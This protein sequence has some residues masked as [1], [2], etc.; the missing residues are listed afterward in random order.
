MIDTGMLQSGAGVKWFLS[1]WVSL[2]CRGYAGDVS[3]IKEYKPIDCTTNPSLLFKVVDLPSYEPILKQ[4]LEA[5]LADPD[6]IDKERPYSGR[7]TCLASSGYAQRLFTQTD[8][9]LRPTQLYTK[10][11]IS[12]LNVGSLDSV[13]WSRVRRA[14]PWHRHTPP[15]HIPAADLVL[16][17]L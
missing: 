12:C 10:R 3:Q 4:A 9:P 16:S 13:S 15:Q 2:T 5:E 7:P 14:L 6:N 1:A 8:R 11:I 17:T